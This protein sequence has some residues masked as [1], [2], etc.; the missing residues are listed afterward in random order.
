MRETTE[1]EHDLGEILEGLPADI[2]AKT[3]YKIIEEA[4]RQESQRNSIAKQAKSQISDR[5]LCETLGWYVGDQHEAH[6]IDVLVGY[7]AVQ[8]YDD[9]GG[10]SFIIKRGADRLERIAKKSQDE[11]VKKSHL[12]AAGNLYAKIHERNAALCY[13]AVE[14]WKAAAEAW[15]DIDDDRASICWEKGEEYEKAANMAERA[16]TNTEKKDKIYRALRLALKGGHKKLAADIALRYYFRHVDAD[17]RQR[18]IR[19]AD[20]DLDLKVDVAS[21]LCQHNDVVA[22]YEEAGKLENAAC[23]AKRFKLPDTDR[24]YN[25]LIK[26]CL[27]EEKLDEA[28]TFAREAERWDYVAQ[29]HEMNGD[30]LTAGLYWKRA[31][32]GEKAQELLQREFDNQIEQGNFLKAA[33]A[34]HELADHKK[35]DQLAYLAKVVGDAFSRF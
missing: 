15:E 7:E 6:I 17:M 34:A 31:G 5:M 13:E 12:I 20:D 2:R 4:R 33:S 16:A 22:L 10:A 27:A 14:R 18:A 28:Q 32:N 1:T 11:W 9:H 19:Y 26:K 3:V 30:I 29:I 25:V 8:R 35:A 21:Q 24:L 23:Y